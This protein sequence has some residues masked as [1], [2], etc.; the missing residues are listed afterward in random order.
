MVSLKTVTLKFLY[1]PAC[2]SAFLNT[3]RTGKAGKTSIYIFSCSGKLYSRQ[4]FCYQ[5]DDKTIAREFLY[6]NT[7]TGE[8]IFCVGLRLVSGHEFKWLEKTVRNFTQ[9]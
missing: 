5:L 9:E 3:V 7:V 1:L 4:L 8:N 2:A 6:K